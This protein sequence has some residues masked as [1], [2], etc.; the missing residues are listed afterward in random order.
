M[1]KKESEKGGKRWKKDK[2]K[3]KGIL[4]WVHFDLI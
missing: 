4:E 2:R 1:P 3:K